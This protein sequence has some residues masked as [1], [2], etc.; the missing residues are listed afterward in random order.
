MSRRIPRTWLIAAGVSAALAL[1]WVS[2]GEE[3]VAE[4]DCLDAGGV[5]RNGACEGRRPGE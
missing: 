1:L 2:W 4:D 5:W 3:F